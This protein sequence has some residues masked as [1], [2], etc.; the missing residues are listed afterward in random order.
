[1]TEEANRRRW[2]DAA[3]H[4]ATYRAT[5]GVVGHTWQ[6]RPHLLL[7][8]TGR[9]SG[10]E[11]TVPLVHTLVPGP[12]GATPL[13]AVVASAGGAERH[14]AW[15]LNLVADPD[16][17]VQLWAHRWRTRAVV[18]EGSQEEAAWAGLVGIWSGFA[19]YRR[20]TARRIPVVLLAAPPDALP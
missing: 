16:V 19:A 10:R 2:V 11:H 5:G 9:R 4:V 6:D 15:Y 8:T 18:A 12:D 13:L 20:D 3:E 14:P 7:S 1:M 17:G